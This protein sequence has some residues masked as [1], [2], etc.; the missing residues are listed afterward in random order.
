MEAIKEALNL[1]CRHKNQRHAKLRA[2]ETAAT[3]TYPEALCKAFARALMEN[4]KREIQDQVAIHAASS[5]SSRARAPEENSESRDEPEAPVEEL[6]P[7]EPER[8]QQEENPEEQEAGPGWQTQKIL[9]QLKVIHANL[10]HPSNQVLCKMLREA[11][12][13]AEVLEQARQ[14]ACPH[15]AQRGHAQPHKTS[16][17]QQATKK[18]EVISVDTF[19]WHSPHRD[20]KGNPVELMK[21]VIT[22]SRQSFVPVA[23]LNVSSVRRSSVKFPVGTGSVYFRSQR[24]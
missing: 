24:A 8:P 4:R 19:W 5:S 10:G 17:I 13:G 22:M 21:R 16:H 7:E 2:F 6:I 11:G 9:K 23:R 1:K 14:F 3:A 18:W 12:A 15:C 20:E